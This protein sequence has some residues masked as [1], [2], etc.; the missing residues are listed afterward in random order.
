MAKDTPDGQ[1]IPV[2]DAAPENLT[3]G[4]SE[5]ASDLASLPLPKAS[6]LLEQ[7]WQQIEDQIPLPP[8]FFRL[9]P[10]GRLIGLA[11][12]QGLTPPQIVKH[13]KLPRST[14]YRWCAHPVVKDLVDHLQMYFA[15]DALKLMQKNVFVAANTI[16]SLAKKA[17]K[18]ST[19]LAAAIHNLDRVI[20]KI[21]DRHQHQHISFRDVLEALK[22]HKV[23]VVEPGPAKLEQAA[24]EAVIIDAKVENVKP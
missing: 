17:D 18:D 21:P 16:T 23:T 6:Q 2:P 11:Q 13:L 1:L 5:E 12:A 8:E 9:K 7:K 3:V 4:E 10:Q 22:T 15:N 20:G 14:V 24:A 19:K